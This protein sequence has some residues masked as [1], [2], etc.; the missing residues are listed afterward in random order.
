MKKR[1]EIHT[2]KAWFGNARERSK[3]VETK[4]EILFDW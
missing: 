3:E 4:E 2:E 1:E